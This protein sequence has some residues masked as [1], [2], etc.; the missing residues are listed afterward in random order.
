MR[1][2]KWFLEHYQS[3]SLFARLAMIL[4]FYFPLLLVLGRALAQSD[5]SNFT[6]YPDVDPGKL[7]SALGISIECLL[8][9]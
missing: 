3:L 1:L 5:A 2:L 8:R 9:L 6:L 7:S 4:Q